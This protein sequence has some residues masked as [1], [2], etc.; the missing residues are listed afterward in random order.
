M[1]NNPI[2]RYDWLGG[3]FEYANSTVKETYR[4]MRE[5]NSNRVAGELKPVQYSITET[6]FEGILLPIGVFNVSCTVIRQIES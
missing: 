5:E 2:L 4:R 6:G 1:G 3:Y